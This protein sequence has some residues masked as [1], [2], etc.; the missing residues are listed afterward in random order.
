MNASTRHPGGR[1]GPVP[2]APFRSLQGKIVST[3]ILLFVVLV[4]ATYLLFQHFWERQLLAAAESQGIAVGQAVEMALAA[5]MLAE[6]PH[7]AHEILRI[8]TASGIVTRARLI[9][10]EGRIQHS[11]VLA[12]E[13]RWAAGV[14]ETRGI[15]S[16][17]TLGREGGMDIRLPIANRTECHRCHSPEAALNGVLELH[18]GMDVLASAIRQARTLASLGAILSITALTF[19]LTALF[20]RH[21]SDPISRILT[22]MSEARQGDLN[23]RVPAANGSDEFGLIGR[24]LNEMLE[25]LCAA[26]AEVESMHRE[27][28]RRSEHLA[29]LGSLA[30]AMAHEIKN[31]LAGIRGAMQ[32][33]QEQMPPEAEHREIIREII[34]QVDRLDTTV[35]DLLTYA[36]PPQPRKSPTDLNDLV[37]SLVLFLRH[38]AASGKVAYEMDLDP[39]LPRPSADPELL[40]QAI[41]NLLQNALQAMPQGGR[42]RLATAHREGQ[43]VLSVS[44]TGPGISEENLA[45]IWQPFFTTR[46]R[47]TGLG[48]SIA[49]NTVSNHGGT[50]SVTSVPGEGATFT[51]ALPVT[52]AGGHA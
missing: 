14:E 41:L 37:R 10:P 47:G 42:L 7:D 34:R 8:A 40:K 16:R 29:T 48:L 19:V 32:V 46:H 38:E 20:R 6:K 24:N 50:I 25:D 11:T 30:A 27:E 28:L 15:V 9:T 17:A 12:E 44:D 2:A 26:R 1:S 31:P 4:G 35:K 43:V 21:V 36:R 3:T 45:R 18:A 22:T 23:A 51:I 13:G 49:R 52:E 33:I 5:T 39:D